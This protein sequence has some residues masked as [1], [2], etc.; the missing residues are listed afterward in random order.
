MKL[1]DFRN[2]SRIAEHL[3]HRRNEHTVTIY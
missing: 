3:V 1:L 2:I